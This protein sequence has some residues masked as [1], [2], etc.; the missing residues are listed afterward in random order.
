MR[1]RSG[2]KQPQPHASWAHAGRPRF[3]RVTSATGHPQ[4]APGTI[5]AVNLLLQL[6]PTPSVTQLPPSCYR[7][8]R[9]APWP[10]SG[11]APLRTHPGRHPAAQALHSGHAVAVRGHGSSAAAHGPAGQGCGAVLRC[12]T[13]S[14]AASNNSPGVAPH[15]QAAGQDGPWHGGNR[16]VYW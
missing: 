2:C 6:L 11:P 16:P 5:L 8:R 7:Y 15:A 1:Q 10:H 3:A 13:G 4:V 9:L 12:R 14:S